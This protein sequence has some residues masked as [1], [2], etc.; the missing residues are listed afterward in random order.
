MTKELTI[1]AS[2]ALALAIAGCGD[3]RSAANKTPKSPTV[4]GDA[5]SS[6]NR[7]E[8]RHGTELERPGQQRHGCCRQH[9]EHTGCGW[10]ERHGFQRRRGKSERH[11]RDGLQWH[12]GHAWQR[13]DERHGGQWQRQ[14]RLERYLDADTACYARGAS[15]SRFR[16]RD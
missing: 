11:R 13:R 7:L 16:D 14:R 9:G 2:V 15:A 1:A 8:R 6:R 4:H 3:D 12:F 5:G 10:D